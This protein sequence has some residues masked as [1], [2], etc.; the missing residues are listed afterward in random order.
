MADGLGRQ[1]VELIKTFQEDHII[2]FYRTR[3]KRQRG[4]NDVDPKVIPIL[5]KQYK[6]AGKIILVEDYECFHP[7]KLQKILG[8]T[9]NREEH[10]LLAYTMFESSK[11]PREWIEVLNKFFDAIIVPDPYQVMVFQSSGANIPVFSLPLG[12]YLEEY[13]KLPLKKEKRRP[14]TF[15][16]FSSLDPR[17]NHMALIRAFS[18]AFGNTAEVQLRLHF[19]YEG[20]GMRESLQQEIG[21]LGLFNVT[22]TSG[23]LPQKDYIQAFQSI[24]CYMNLSKGEGFSIQPREAMAL[25]IPVIVSDNTSQHT[26]AES[27]LVKA[28][29]AKIK[30]PAYYPHIKQFCGSFYL[31]HIDEAADAMRDVYLH[32]EK[33]LAKGQEARNW[34]AQYDFAQLKKYYQNLIKPKQILFGDKNE[35]T[36]EYLMTSSFPLFEKYRKLTSANSLN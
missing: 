15:A 4:Y 19:R 36:E 13:L 10:I 22:I 23:P 21:R 1:S 8:K 29:P 31:F 25:G 5:K 28:V 33:Y 6:E 16:S 20:R 26:I 24:D 27:Q 2:N 14:F 34:A 30:E 11:A 35:I 12:L 3:K 9:K 7:Y 18:K 17:K 32:Y